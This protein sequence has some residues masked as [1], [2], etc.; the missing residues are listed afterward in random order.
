[1]EYLDE[2]LAARDGR[3]V[4]DGAVEWLRWLTEEVT[5]GG[6]LSIEG[7]PAPIDTLPGSRRDVEAAGGGGGLAPVGLLTRLLRRSAR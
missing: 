4:T 2:T 6:R 3:P 1:M 5:D 7:L